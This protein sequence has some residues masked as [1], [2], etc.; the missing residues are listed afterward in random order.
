MRLALERAR[1]K[2][3]ARLGCLL[4]FLLA[5]CSQTGSPAGSIP[6]TVVP[7]GAG[8]QA[9]ALTGTDTT[10]T[11]MRATQ[12]PKPTVLAPDFWQKMPVIPGQLSERVRAIYLDGLAL[13]RNLHTFSRIG[14]CASAAPDFLVGF[15]NHYNLGEYTSLQPAI[16]Y[17]QGSFGRP[18]LAAKAGLNSAGLLTSLW[19]GS[20]CMQKESLLDCEYRIDNPRIAFIPIGT[21][22][23]YYVHQNP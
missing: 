23:A 2:T 19:T 6:E 16:D 17:F 20:Q 11:E 5:A 7:A 9:T 3:A 15:D 10:A 13:G 14:D 4:L 22:E 18:S 8:A 1:L 12:V 21:N